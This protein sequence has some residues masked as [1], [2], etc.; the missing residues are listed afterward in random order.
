LPLRIER[1]AVEGSRDAPIAAQVDVPGTWRGLS[2]RALRTVTWPQSQVRSLQIRFA[3]SPG[4]V[5]RALTHAGFELGPVGDIRKGTAGEH[6]VAF[7]IEEISEGAAL[8]CVR[9]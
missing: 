3:S 4:E 9:G 6:S 1:L 8:T 7:R 5:R 2:V